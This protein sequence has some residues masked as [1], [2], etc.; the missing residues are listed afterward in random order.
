[1]KI[2]M[3]AGAVALA[4][5]PVLSHAADW[6][7]GYAGLQLGYGW[8]DNDTSSGEGEIGGLHGGYLIDRGAYV[9]GGEIDYDF[10]EV[11]FSGG[12]EIDSIIRLKGK[13]GYDLGETLVYGT[14][15]VAFAEATIG[16]TSFDDTGWFIG[17]GVDQM[18]TENISIGAELLHHD[19]NEFDNSGTDI[20]GTTLALRASYHF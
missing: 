16:G 1:M 2:T 12:D 19:F 5:L 4:T 6:T 20:D 17:V 9:F 15:G 11:D 3:I 18:V 8:L 7:G 14:L 13:A 10:T